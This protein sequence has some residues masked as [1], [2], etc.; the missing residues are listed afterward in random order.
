LAIKVILAQ[1]A[2]D[3]ELRERFVRETKVMQSL[4]HPH[5][6]PV[7]ASGEEHGTL[8]FVMPFVR[9]PSVFELLERRRFSPLMAWQIL[10]PAAQALDYAHK[11]GVIHRDIKPGNLLVQA[12]TGKSNHVYLVDF[13]LSK[14]AGV[15]TLNRNEFT[16]GTPYY[17]APEQIM[18]KLPSPQTD[19]Y[20]L[21]ILLYELLLGCLPFVAKEP[22]DIAFQHVHDAPPPPHEL[23]PDFPKPLEDV[24][25]RALAKKPA[26]RYQS[27]GE[28]R[29]AYARAV[30]AMDPAARRIEYWVD[31]Q[32]I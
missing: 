27:A 28:F 23:H 14:I 6:M 13:G 31:E 4:Q 32:M 12:G 24:L 17:M 15:E 1:Y 2:E 22:S 26:Q 29:M 30:E 11:L 3:P 10:S 21:G 16:L 18:A 20:S 9:G 19:I 7:Y 25:L 5:I 8:Y